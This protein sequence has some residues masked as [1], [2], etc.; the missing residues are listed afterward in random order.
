MRAN[1]AGRASTRF[2]AVRVQPQPLV[3]GRIEPPRLVHD[4]GGDAVQ[5]D[6]VQQCRTT[7]HCGVGFGQPGDGGGPTRQL[8]NRAGMPGPA[9][10][11]V[12]R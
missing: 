2:G 4:A 3:L 1:A 5:A 11:T 7:K 10:T 8:G 9:M 12:G 6:V